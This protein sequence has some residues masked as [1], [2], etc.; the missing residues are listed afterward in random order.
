MNTKKSLIL[1]LAGVM[2]LMSLASCA[3]TGD[4]SVTETNA[5]PAETEAVTAVP[6]FDY[7]EAD[8]TG[9]V[10]ITKEDYTGLTISIPNSY[11]ITDETVADYIESICFQNRVAENGTTQVTDKA[12][13]LGDDAYIYY[14]GFLGD[15]AFDGGSNWDDESP[16]Q[17]GLGSGTFIPG[18]EDALVGIVPNTTSKDNPAEIQVTFPEDYDEKLA[19]KEATF[20]IVVVYAVQY[21]MPAYTREFVETTLKYEPK[22]DYVYTDGE[23]LAE[24]EEYIRESLVTN[25][26]TSLE[27]AKVDALW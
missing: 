12:L 21:Q 27:N 2:G 7:M 25:M 17:L 24:Y 26:A 14:K 16:Y 1:L 5:T 6:R 9:D 4:P 3:S 10:T 11:K 20:R 13:K 18:F 19:G 22:K 23:F 8:M 15:E